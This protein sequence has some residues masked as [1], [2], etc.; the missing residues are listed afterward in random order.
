M[1]FSALPAGAQTLFYP[2]RTVFSA[3]APQATNTFGFEEFNLAP[4][5]S[6][7][8]F[9]T[10]TE[11][12]YVTFNSNGNYR[13]EVIDGFNVGQPNNNV[14]VTIAS[15]TTGTLADITFGAGV[16]AVGFDLKN[17]ASA[18]GTAGAVPQEFTISL[19]SGSATLGSFAVLTLPGGSLF[20]FAGFTSDSPITQ[21]TITS[22]GLSP[23]LDVV[24]DNFQVSAQVPEPGTVALAV[25]GGLGLFA[26]GRRRLK[27]RRA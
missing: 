27:N 25:V 1:L 12:G 19:F 23:N 20:S 6:T 2:N 10:L 26:A 8:F 7:G 4:G 9:S 13:Q 15:L 22:T 21:L 11:L 3:A 18:G 17:T 24:L 14:Y 5:T 16:S